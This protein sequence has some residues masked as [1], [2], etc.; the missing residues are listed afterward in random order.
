MSVPVSRSG[1]RGPSGARA[2]VAAAAVLCGALAA[3][4]VYGGLR[5]AESGRER[6]LQAWQGKLGIVADSRAAAVDSWLEGQF[7]AIGQIAGNAAVQLYA[8]QIAAAAS[9]RDKAEANQARAGY[10]RNFLSVIADGKGFAR[11]VD[12]PRVAANVSRTGVAGIAVIARDGRVLAATDGMPPV[13]G[14]ILDTLSLASD[15]EAR[16][17]DLYREKTGAYSIGFAVPVFAVQAENTA[18]DQVGWVVGVKPVA[19]ELYPLLRQP[20][21]VWHSAEG[22]LVRRVDAGIEYLS[23]TGADDGGPGRLFAADTRNLAGAFAVGNP[24]GFALRRDYRGREVLLAARRIRAA[25]WT[26]YYKI[27]RD[28]ALGPA[29]ARARRLLAWMLGAL[30]AAIAVIAAAWRHGTSV[31]YARAA[32]EA[33]SLARRYAAQ[34][35][36]LRLITD[37]QPAAMFIVDQDDRYRFANRAAAD[38]AGIAADDLIGKSLASVLGP[39]AAGRYEAVNREVRDSGERRVTV[40]QSGTNGDLCVVQAEHIPIGFDGAAGSP[41]RPGGASPGILIVEEDITTAV[42]ERARRERTLRQLVRTVLAILDRRDPHAADHSNRVAALA[43]AVALEMGLDEAT[44][45][46]AETAGQLMNIGK[47]LVPAEMLTREGGLAEAELRLVRD[48]LEAA[49]DLLD[50]VEFDGPVV[51]T[52]RQI[53]ERWDGRGTPRG[54]SGDGILIT[55]QIVAVANAFVALTSDR[56]WRAGTDGASAAGTLMEEAGGA[57]ARRVVSALINIVDNR[58][59]PAAAHR[60]PPA[61]PP[62]VH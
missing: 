34:S 26:L 52:L 15:G 41:D 17:L 53:H 8:T 46:T 1:K 19:E 10:L 55:A 47:A 22:L 36:F 44:A 45:T 32:A 33:E 30:V 6:D 7:A 31:R 27:D 54:L 24:G 38:G 21:T 9:T 58:D 60:E 39:A 3:A 5:L 20:G 42:A 48:S 62:P 40:H 49:A 12:G 57:F 28:E 14:R 50:G 51:A 56:S 25:P 29:D 59:P 35:D 61:A 23:P 11:P 2:K 16:L 4:S 37:S 13:R 18:A 43:R